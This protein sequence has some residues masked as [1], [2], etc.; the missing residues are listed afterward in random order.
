MVRHLKIYAV[1]FKKRAVRID[2]RTWADVH[3]SIDLKKFQ[4]G[5]AYNV[6]LVQN[7]DGRWQLLSAEFPN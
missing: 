3:Y 1:S 5:Q 2:D 6:E 7:L 4:V